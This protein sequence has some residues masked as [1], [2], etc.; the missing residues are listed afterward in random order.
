MHLRT[1]LFGDHNRDSPQANLDI[2]IDFVIE[3]S[4]KIEVVRAHASFESHVLEV[5]IAQF[6]S[7]E[8]ADTRFNLK[9]FDFAF[10]RLAE[11]EAR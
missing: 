4:F 3:I 8:L 7:N 11:E 2:H 6:V 9:V 5:R 10:I 1:R